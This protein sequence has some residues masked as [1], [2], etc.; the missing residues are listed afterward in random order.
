MNKCKILLTAILILSSLC[1]EILTAQSTQKVLTL[2]DVLRLAKDQSPQALLSRHKY[3]SSYW[4]FRSFKAKYLPNLNLN[5]I[6]PNFTHAISKIPQEDGTDLFILQRQMDNYGTLSL[7]QNIGLTGGTISINSYLE[8]LDFLGD[9]IYHNFNSNPIGIKISQP[10]LSFNP[11]KW[12]RKI[13][14]LKYE[15]AKKA[16]IKSMED[17]SRSAIDFFFDLAQS[18]LILQISNVNYFNADTLYKIAKGRYNIGTIAENE[19]LQMEL[20]LLNAGTQL[21]EA[22]I[23]L[24]LKKSRLRSFLG[25]NE[26]VEIV[27]QIPTLIPKLKVDYKRVYEEAMKNNPDILDMDR[28]ILEAMQNVAQARAA[29]RINVTLEASYGLTQASPQFSK[30]YL[31]PLDQELVQVGVRM[32]IVDWGMRRGQY[33]MAE[34]NEEVVR[35][36][37]KQAQ[38]DF[39]QNVFLQVM[40]FNVQDKQFFAAAKAD[41]VAQLRYELSKQRFMIGK[42]D[43][44]NLNVSLTDKDAAKRSYIDALHTYWAYYFTIRQISLYDFEADKPL[45]AD[46]DSLLN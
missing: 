22:Q 37:V 7:Q 42:I 20:S 15:E 18:Q 6:L 28:Q 21:T 11:M 46:L 8:R 5:G 41:T 12:E 9:S 35:T 36:Q 33:K 19:L 3:R 13:E 40:R 25:Y 27:L 32:P 43:V 34:S 14:P 1:P 38:I 24:E 26:S 4:E 16:Y 2:D 44:L 29:K 30:V 39:Q 31:N 17:V 45:D 23:D 10:I